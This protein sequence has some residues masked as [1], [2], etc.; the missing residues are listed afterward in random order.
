MVI[1]DCSAVGRKSWMCG[2]KSS[3]SGWEFKSPPAKALVVIN[4]IF[5]T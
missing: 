5:C 3:L 1:V 4:E 2:A